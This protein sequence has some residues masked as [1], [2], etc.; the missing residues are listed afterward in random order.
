LVGYK[1]IPEILIKFWSDI[2]N[3]YRTHIFAYLTED[4]GITV[5]D[6]D[7]DDELMPYSVLREQILQTLNEMSDYLTNL[8]NY[9][10]QQ[11]ESG[12]VGIYTDAS[13][14]SLE[15]KL[16]EEFLEYYKEATT[17][18][19][20]NANELYKYTNLTL[21]DVIDDINDLRDL[22]NDL[23]DYVKN[24]VVF[25]KKFHLYDLMYDVNLVKNMFEQIADAPNIAELA[26]GE[27]E[28]EFMEYEEAFIDS[29]RLIDNFLNKF[30]DLLEKMYEK[31]VQKTK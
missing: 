17:W 9:I 14:L 22:I 31:I 6:D 25:V 12:K 27:S 11:V 19:K 1:V 18:L 13:V 21:Y 7:N 10:N 23:S 24:M 8:I 2:L 30:E 20:E 16:T 29:V 26:I 15:N 28:E 3:E 4:V 5:K